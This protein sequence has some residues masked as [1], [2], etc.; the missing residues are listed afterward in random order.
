MDT[1]GYGRS[2]GATV[3]ERWVTG[4]LLL[5]ALIGICVG[6]Y[7]W[8]D[9]TAPQ[10]L[11]L[12]MLGV[13]V[14]VAVVGLGSAGRRVQ[15]TRYRP[16]SWLGAEFFTV[17]VGVAVAVLGWYVGRSQVVVAYPGVDVMPYL[18]P[19]ALALG[20]LGALPAVATPVPASAPVRHEVAV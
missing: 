4:S 14:S 18:S 15:R 19:L 11:A 5:L 13:G 1:R 6:T 2:G 20:V 8:L 16:D 3:R 10:V 7:A 17:G 9:P 12:P